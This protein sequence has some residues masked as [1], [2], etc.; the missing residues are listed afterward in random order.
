MVNARDPASVAH[1]AA[2]CGRGQTVALLGS[3][4]VGKSTLVDTLRGSDSIATQA[5]RAGDDTGRHTTTVRTMHR[6]AQ[7]GWLLDTPGMREV[8]LS[9]PPPGWP[10]CSTMSRR[11]RNSAA[12]RT[13]RMVTSR[14]ARCAVRAAMAEGALTME[15]FARW[16]KL[17]AEDRPKVVYPKTTG[18]RR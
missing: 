18:R 3:S 12:F 14:A 8:Q 15:R 10:R 7:G 9:K 2:W 13:A 6:L 16:R 5:I 17:E 11:W 1:L 4:G